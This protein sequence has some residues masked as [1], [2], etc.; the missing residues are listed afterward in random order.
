ML[1]KCAAGGGAFVAGAILSF[2]AFPTQA[3]PGTVAPEVLR[4]MALSKLPIVVVFNLFSIYCLSR[5]PL[6]RADHERNAA[7]L[8]ERRAAERDEPPPAAHPEPAV[9]S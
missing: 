3:V 9:A 7:I 1:D 5:Y 8:A 4:D 6:T 2:V